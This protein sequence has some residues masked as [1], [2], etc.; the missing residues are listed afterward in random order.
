MLGNNPFRYEVSEVINKGHMSTCDYA[1]GVI[2]C[3]K[4]T[5]NVINVKRMSRY[6]DYIEDYAQQLL[7]TV[8]T[9]L[10]L[11]ETMF[12][13]DLSDVKLTLR[14]FEMPLNAPFSYAVLTN[15][16]EFTYKAKLV[17]V[18]SD[19]V[20]QNNLM[21]NSAAV[22]R[23]TLKEF[24]LQLL[25]PCF[26][27][28]SIK[29]VG[30]PFRDINGV[31]LMRT[32]L[33]KFSTDDEIDA[34]TAVKGVDIAPGY[35]EA[36]RSQIVI[37]H[38]TPLVKALSLINQS[39]GGVYPTGFSFYLQNQLWYIFPPYDIQR[40]NKTNR[41]IT[42]V[43]LPKDQMPNIEKTYYNTDTKL[44][45]LSTRDAKV[46]DRRES[47]M[48]NN[49][50][51]IRF[52][53]ANR[54]FDGMGQVEDNKFKIDISKN[55]NDIA[56]KERTDGANIL[57]AADVKIT[58]NKNIEL[59]KL[60]K[61]NGFYYQVTWEH[62]DDSLLF[63]G[64]PAKI[65]YLKDNKPASATGTLIE[66]ETIWVPAENNFKNVKLKRVSA[67]TFFVGNEQYVSN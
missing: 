11:Y 12:H 16:R 1:E 27:S 57:R 43:N 40:F 54:L 29:T 23:S 64:M 48:F 66:S 21:V 31:G 42:V 45:V 9:T 20:S 58:A 65:L 60:A 32:L 15:P 8:T 46:V 34:I 55:V 25:E 26:E 47:M 61:N 50:N 35:N 7:V 2:E 53:E 14:L 52:I 49:G 24:T 30:G 22:M 38:A 59:G 6:R 62:S 3:S 10:E 17:N 18:A 63:P 33:T 51:A 19:Q 41:T 39:C 37:P 13:S 28:V 44:I 5:F 56:L 4:G 36:K 67:L